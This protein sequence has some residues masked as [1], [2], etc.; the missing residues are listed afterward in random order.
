MMT[1]KYNMANPGID[2]LVV[3]DEIGSR[4]LLTEILSKAGYRVRPADGSLVALESALAH[5]PSLILLD[6][7]MPEMSGF[8]VSRKLTQDDRT[9]DI[10]IIFVSALQDVEDRV[11]GFESG[12]VDF[13]SKPFE[14]S[15]VL[16]RVKTHLQL[17]EMQIH[18]EELVSAR[19]ADLLQ[20]NEVLSMEIIERKKTEADLQASQ[21]L[22][23]LVIENLPALVAYVDKHKHY[24]F[25]NQRFEQYYGMPRSEFIGKYVSEILGP[26]GYAAAESNIAAV[27]AGEE[28]SYE[29]IFKY[30]DREQRWM[31]V[32]YVPDIDP[33]GDIH[34]F[35]ALIRD[36]TESKIAEIQLQEYQQRLKDLA[37]QLTLTEERERRRV[38]TELHDHVGQSLAFARMRLAS[39]R[40]TCSDPETQTILDEISESLLNAI[41][42]TKNLVFDLSSPLLHE[43]GLGEAV[44]EWLV[45]QVGKRYGLETELIDQSPDIRLDED[46]RAI[47]FRNVREL[48]TNVVRHAHASKVSVQLRQAGDKIQVIIEDDGVGFDPDAAP[49]TAIREEGFGL[50]S[51]QERM[52][53]MG[54][55]FMIESEP[56]QGT[57]AVLSLPLSN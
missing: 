9:R 46:I 13:I 7:R 30:P 3:D 8:E 17:R 25:V 40:K 43:L 42:D 27:L 48:L 15:E 10:P 22:L 56:D 38:A 51:I 49:K 57:K 35:I 26:E 37:T 1:T 44:D 14:E 36:I 12:G 23:S 32:N 20:T 5:P 11:Q 16:A 29:Q 53:D 21:R 39:A 28:L 55:D 34:G 54:G 45:E 47:L 24:R 2:I 6:V 52:S 50:F 33:T 18:L 31:Q 4:R 19:T 41:R